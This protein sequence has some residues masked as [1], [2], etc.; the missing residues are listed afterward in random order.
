MRRIDDFLLVKELNAKLFRHSISED[1]LRIATCAPS[2][3]YDYDYERLEMLGVLRF[4]RFDVN[5]TTFTMFTRRCFLEI[6]VHR[7]CVR[8][9]SIP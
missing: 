9:L 8:H 6:S 2:A 7:L 4:R 5:L 3:G 1:L